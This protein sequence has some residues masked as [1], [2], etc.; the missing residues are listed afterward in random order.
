[1]SSETGRQQCPD[2]GARRGLSIENGWSHCFACG[3]NTPLEGQR[4]E[5][6]S[7]KAPGKLLD[8][9]EFVALGK[10]KLT[11]E[12]CKFWGYGTTELKDKPVQ[13]AQ[14]RNDAGAVIAQKIRTADKGFAWFGNHDA[15]G[16]YGKHLWRDA[17]KKLV[18]T[19][20]EIDAMSVSQVQDLKWPVVSVPD[21]AQSAPKAILKDLAWLERY[22]Q[23]IFMFDMDE[24]G[25]KAAAECALLLSPGKAFIA[26]LPLKDANEMLQAGKVKQLVDAIWGAKQFRPD[27]IVAGTEI[28]DKIIDTK[29]FDSLPYPWQTLNGLTHG[30]R[31][32]EMVVLCAGTGVGKS[33]VARQIAASFHDN[34]KE[35]IGYIALEE[36]VQRTALGF[37]GLQLGRRLHVDPGDLAGPEIRAA[38]DQTVG[39][40]RY[41]LYDHWGSLEGDHLLARIRYM[42][43]GLGCS[44]IV[45]DH[46]SIVISGTETN[47]ERKTIDLVMT[48]LRSLVEELQF[49]LI[50]I[51]HLKRVEGKP[52]EEGGRVTLAHLRG[53]G[54]IGQLA[55]IAIALERNQQDKTKGNFTRIR[56]LKNR[57]T[58]ETGVAG[59]LEYD[60]KTGRLAEAELPGSSSEEE[61][62]ADESD[63]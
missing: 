33:E 55:N 52:H 9:L 19:E 20:G 57:F 31:R 38:F 14:Y 27:G 59:W 36:S 5:K 26:N 17:G 40:G 45:L 60:T 3:K 35:T 46:I 30:C 34:H 12:T 41:F 28:Y 13:V 62:G 51:S 18:I 37:I 42:V 48:K 29:G 6:T 39:S 15:V 10:R 1:M 25:R 22:E 54:S 24:P 11:E 47:D 49:R 7:K 43:R 32:G 16:L 8:G 50:I 53:S 58:G 4:L 21:G 61:E 56:V 2:C 63:F 44:T 23:V